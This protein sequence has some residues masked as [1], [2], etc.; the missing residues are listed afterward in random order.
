MTVKTDVNRLEKEIG[1]PG[2][3]PHGWRVVYENDWRD[4]RPDPGPEVCGQCG[5]PKQTVKVRYE[6]D[7]RSDDD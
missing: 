1:D 6:K 3:C 5:K 2:M 4:D 7:W